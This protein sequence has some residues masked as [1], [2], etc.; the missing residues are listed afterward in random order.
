MHP[1][2]FVYIKT[3]LFLKI[4]SALIYVNLSTASTNPTEQYIRTT[5]SER[6]S[7]AEEITHAIG[8]VKSYSSIRHTP[9][10]TCWNCL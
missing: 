9:T 2:S 8:H 5:E 1:Y 3:N 6:C 7:L 10:S 4:C